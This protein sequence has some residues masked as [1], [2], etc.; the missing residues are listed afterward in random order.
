MFRRRVRR[1]FRSHKRIERSTAVPP[2]SLRGPQ[3]RGAQDLVDAAKARAQHIEQEAVDWAEHL[4][5]TA[6]QRAS[7]IVADAEDRA[8]HMVAKSSRLTRGY[9]RDVFELLDSALP[10]DE[11]EDRRASRESQSQS[12]PRSDTGRPNLGVVPNANEGA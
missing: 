5:S 12:W 9:L 7:D 11:P 2:T 6:Q 8:D 4:I 10:P 3:T 1:L